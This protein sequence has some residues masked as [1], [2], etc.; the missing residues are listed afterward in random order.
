MT[1][2]ASTLPHLLP[3][4]T[5]PGHGSNETRRCFLTGC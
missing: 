3:T 4:V 5:K 2:S 1:R